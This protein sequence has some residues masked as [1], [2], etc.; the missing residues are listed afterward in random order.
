MDEKVVLDEKVNPI[1]IESAND[2]PEWRE[3]EEANLLRLIQKHQMREQ[4]RRYSPFYFIKS[5]FERR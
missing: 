2:D 4:R 1:R 5:K 3:R